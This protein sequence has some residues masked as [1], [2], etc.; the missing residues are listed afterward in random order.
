MVMPFETNGHPPDCPGPVV[1]GR[2]RSPRLRGAGCAGCTTGRVA[3]G[4]GLL[5]P[6]WRAEV[7]HAVIRLGLI[8]TVRRLALGRR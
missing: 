5:P 3:L 6:Q 1:A 8:G 4:G 7:A 2:L